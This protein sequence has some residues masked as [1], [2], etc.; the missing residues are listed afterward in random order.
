MS[1]VTLEDWLRLRAPPVPASFLPHLLEAGEG[2]HE[3]LD[4]AGRGAASLAKALRRPGRD[5]EA[6]F[7]LLSADAFLTYACEAV[8]QDWDPKASLEA[9]LEG[10]GDRFR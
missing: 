6:A 7:H 10:L 8:A 5:R 3:P 4:L 1:K 9:V 2:F